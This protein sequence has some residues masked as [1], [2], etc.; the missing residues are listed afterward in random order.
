MATT[1]AQPHAVPAVTRAQALAFRRTVQ[2]LDVAPGTTALPDAPVL[3]LGV[4]DTG[5]DGALWALAVRGVAVDDPWEDLALAWTL[6]GGPHAYRRADLP[7]VA[8]ALVPMSAADAAKRVFDAARPLRAAGIPLPRAW[9]EVARAHAAV[10]TAP[11]VKGEVSARLTA[12]LP[13][14][15]RRWCRPCQAI[16]LYEQTFRL[17]A[18]HAGIT[19][20]PGTSPPVL[21]PASGRPTDHLDGFET[22]VRMPYAERGVPPH[23]DPVRAY[24]HMLGPARPADVTAYLDAPAADVRHRWTELTTAGELAEVL[25]DGERRWVLASDLAALVS[26]PTE[27]PPRRCGCSRRSTPGCRRATAS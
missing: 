5:P 20:E 1:N 25:V 27:H 16:H 10:V 13:E 9:V 4:Q 22:L 8:H 24:L 26:A 14:P 19:L 23:L 6:R 21:T 17:P 18:L 15:Y 2:R 3:D 12:T 7:G 11:T